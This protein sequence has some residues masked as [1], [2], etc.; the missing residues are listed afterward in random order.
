MIK[1]KINLKTRRRYQFFKEVNFTAYK[2]VIARMG[3]VV[4][5]AIIVHRPLGVQPLFGEIPV[6]KRRIFHIPQCQGRER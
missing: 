3:I 1:K 5:I 2:N 4:A 6:F